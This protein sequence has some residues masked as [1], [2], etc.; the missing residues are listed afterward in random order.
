[1]NVDDIL[2]KVIPT[3]F[4][5]ADRLDLIFARQHTLM[6][7]YIPIEIANK[8]CHTQDCPVDIHDRYGQA[9]LKDFFWRVTEEL[10]EAAE[11][12]RIHP[13]LRNHVLEE[14][15]DALHFLV[16]ANLL[17]DIQ[18]GEYVFTRDGSTPV[19]K[20]EWVTLNGHDR[21]DLERGCWEII[22]F[23]GAASNCLKNRPWKQNHQ[24][25]DLKKFRMYLV[26][27]LPI[28]IDVFVGQGLTADEIFC[29]Y[30]KKSE[31]NKFRQ[32]SNY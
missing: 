29:I 24:L 23:L 21:P 30:W 18:P 25:T 10:T 6:D 8:L 5:K 1:M 13:E 22:Y 7:K 20:L 2:G 27:C 17:A 3:D 32:R 31:V 14:L 15:A 26:Q 12:N 11:A 9:R 4:S 28:L 19:C 16:E